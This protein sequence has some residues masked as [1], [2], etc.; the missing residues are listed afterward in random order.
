MQLSQDKEFSLLN[1]S[2]GKP[3]AFFLNFINLILFL[4]IISIDNLITVSIIEY[5]CAII[6]GFFYSGQNS[7]AVR[8][9]CNS[10]GA[11]HENSELLSRILIFKI[12]SLL[13]A[14]SFIYFLYPV[15][16]FVLNFQIDI[17]KDDLNFLVL[18]ILIFMYS[19][20]IDFFQLL[21]IFLVR[22][23]K[24]KINF[25]TQVF[26]PACILVV[27]LF[28]I[29]A[30]I[31]F[32]DFFLLRT[33]FLVLLTIIFIAFAIRFSLISIKLPSSQL[34]KDLPIFLEIYKK[35]F[36]LSLASV[37]TQISE[38]LPI[39]LLSSMGSTAIS[40]TLILINKFY[41]PIKNAITNLLIIMHGKAFQVGE[42]SIGNLNSFLVIQFQKIAIVTLAFFLIL[43]ILSFLYFNNYVGSQSLDEL[44]GLYLRFSALF[45][46]IVLS[47]NTIIFNFHLRT[48]ILGYMTAITAVLKYLGVVAIL[49]D[50]ATLS[51]LI[52]IL[53]LSQLLPAIFT[54]YL[55]PNSSLRDK[56]VI[57]ISIYIL[58]LTTFM[59]II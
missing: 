47:F 3:L 25:L 45:L 43:P 4:E 33:I 40:N 22:I 8:F 34:I 14:L 31:T 2:I 21:S 38:I 19:F 13:I 46:V 15:I 16:T 39:I 48:K 11:P 53:I 7:L 6:F 9:I 37:F 52:F 23:D 28:S 42:N 29:A 54:T 32:S 30:Q 44:Y 20:L 12:T 49:Y 26:I 50:K 5:F 35:Q 51:L 59:S 27:S 1:I 41:V 10:E 56:F 55:I 57:I 18:A 24:L 58:S 17:A 36:P